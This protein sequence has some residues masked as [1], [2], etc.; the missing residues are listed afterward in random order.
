M[1]YGIGTDV[2]EVK[3][4]KES[5]FKHG[6]ALAKKILTSQE[7]LTYKKTKVKEFYLNDK[8]IKNY[9]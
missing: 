7:L 1:I 2:V 5:F 4:I 9:T 6:Q 3:R 8:I